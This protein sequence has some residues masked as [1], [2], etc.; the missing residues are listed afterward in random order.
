M[1][2]HPPLPPGTNRCRCSGCDRSFSSVS[3]FDK[4]QLIAKDGSGICLDPAERGLVLIR[5]YWSSPPPAS[6]AVFSRMETPPRDETT[7][8][9]V[10]QGVL[11]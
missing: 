4:H 8:R 11:L 7:E 9:S 5:G 3:A 6:N 1:T 2:D 10:R